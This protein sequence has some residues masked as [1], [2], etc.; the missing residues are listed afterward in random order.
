MATKTNNTK[1][2]TVIGILILGLVALS[3]S[4]ILIK[5]STNLESQASARPS[6]RP[7]RLTPTPS[8]TPTTTNL[9]YYKKTDG[10]FTVQ[11]NIAT[12]IVAGCHP[13][14]IAI[15]AGLEMMGGRPENWVTIRSTPS[16]A[17]DMNGIL[18]TVINKDTIP[19]DATI[20]T[21]CLDK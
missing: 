12:T 20:T 10:N 15:S 3:I 11:P 16:T 2:F 13:G 21:S 1:I 8:A 18:V 9:G 4:Q 6:P 14:D 7:T 5:T 19:L 17:T